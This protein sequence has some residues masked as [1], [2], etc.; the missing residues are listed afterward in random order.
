MGFINTDSKKANPLM[1]EMQKVLL[2]QKEEQEVL[3]KKI[4]LLEDNINNAQ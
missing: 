1:A 3:L 4:K 2:R